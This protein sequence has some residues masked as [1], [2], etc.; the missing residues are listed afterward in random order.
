MPVHGQTGT[1]HILLKNI[2]TSSEDEPGAAILGARNRT[3]AS[4]FEHRRSD[5]I[6][7]GAVEAAGFT[8]TWQAIFAARSYSELFWN[9]DELHICRD[10]TNRGP[11]ARIG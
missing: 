6:P 8:V 10:Q 5:R 11:V 2:W 4:E 7:R 1:K 9:C 3:G